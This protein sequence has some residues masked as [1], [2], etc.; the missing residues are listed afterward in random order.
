VSRLKR[1]PEERKQRP[2]ASPAWQPFAD[3]DPFVL[4]IGSSED[5]AADVSQKKYAYLW[6]IQ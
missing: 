5:D 6:L 2:Q 1:I 4:L 3:Q